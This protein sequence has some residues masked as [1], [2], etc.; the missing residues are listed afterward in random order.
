M[1]D[2]GEI[3]EGELRVGLVGRHDAVDVPLLARLDDLPG[4][5]GRDVD[6]PPEALPRLLAPPLPEVLHGERPVPLP[7]LPPLFFR[8]RLGGQVA[9]V[10]HQDRLDV[11]VEQEVHVLH[12]VD[13]VPVGRLVL[14]QLLGAA[15]GPLVQPA[16]DVD[17]DGGV[18][19]FADVARTGALLEE[20]QEAGDPHDD[21]ST[22]FHTFTLF[23]PFGGDFVFL[24]LEFGV[25]V[26][27]DPELKYHLRYLQRIAAQIILN[28]NNNSIKII[29]IGNNGIK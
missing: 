15:E 13:Y 9:A 16:V 4:H 14:H 6:A 24:F 11:V 21:S 25:K 22:L 5:G 18:R 19:Q 17:G 29:D 20:R 1:R 26:V 27:Q 7:V 8:L 2:T 3:Q 23:C 10:E 28:N 12:D